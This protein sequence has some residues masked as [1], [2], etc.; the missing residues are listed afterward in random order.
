MIKFNND[1]EGSQQFGQENGGNCAKL[2]DAIANRLIR[3]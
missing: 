3:I 2:N 1:L